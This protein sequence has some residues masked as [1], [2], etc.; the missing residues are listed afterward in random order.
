[1]HMFKNLIA[2]ALLLLL[3]PSDRQVAPTIGFFIDTWQPKTFVAPPSGVV[4]APAPTNAGPTLTIDADSII[5]RIP[6]SAFGHNV[7][8]WIGTMAT[9]STFLTNVTNLRPHILR[10]PGGS[11]SDAY[12]WNCTPGQWPADVP[13]FLPDADG[14]KKATHLNYGR[15]TTDKIS[16]LDDYYAMLKATGAQGLITVNYGYARYGTSSNPVAA[17]AHLAADWVRYD[18]GRTRYWEIGNENNGFWEYGYRIDTTMNKDGQPKLLTGDL[19]GRHFRVFADSMRKA[20]AEV[21]ATIYIGAVTTETQPKPWD[22]PIMRNWNAGMMK[23]IQDQADYYV[24]HSYFT[25][26][27]QNTSARDILYDATTTPGHIMDYVQQCLRENGAAI[28]PIA[29][30]EW[31]MFAVGSRQQVSNISGLFGVI[32]VGEALRN[33]FGLAARWDLSNGWAGG[34]DHGLFSAGDEPGVAR[35]SPRPSFYYL[36]YFQWTMGDRLVE[37]RVS[38]DTCIRAYASRFSSGELGTALLNTDSVATTVTVDALHFQTARRTPGP[39]HDR[40]AGHLYYW[41][42]LHGGDDNGDFS[43]KVFVND[44]GPAGSAGGPPDYAT[45]KANATSTSRGIRVTVPAHGAVFLVIAR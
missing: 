14:K 1:M 30:D 38:G 26:Y 29:M 16:S 9:Q 5:T 32:V 7:D 33:K 2:I 28:K 40:D 21:G 25:P 36:Y 31:N 23:S 13:D 17:A 20:A 24:V 42:S 19:Y 43:A 44:K 11:A 45:L 39:S 10:W 15:P 41:Y 34:N 12:F 8:F 22:W 37:S 3:G 27:N 6:L 18:H 35:W 4:A